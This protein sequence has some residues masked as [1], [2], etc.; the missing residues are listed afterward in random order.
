[1]FRRKEGQLE[2]LLAHPG[3]PYSARK[4]DGVWTIP[5]GEPDQDGEDLLARAIIEFEEEVGVPAV[6]DWIAIGSIIQ[7]GGKV[8][9][10]WAFEGDLP[11]TFQHQ[12]NNFEMEWPPHSGKLQPFPE[13]DRVA[14]FPVAEAHRKIK[15]TQAPF[16]D[17]LVA[18]VKGT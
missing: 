5:K 16:L 18:I 8:V 1:M 13:I 15:A 14:F 4:D 3:G 11:D 7:K 17:R 2:V 6:G 12:S 10:G 9:H